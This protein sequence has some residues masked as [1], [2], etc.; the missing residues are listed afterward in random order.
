MQNAAVSS[1][2]ID[3]LPAD[4]VV[5][6]PD[7]SGLSSLAA[8]DHAGLALALEGLTVPEVPPARVAQ[9]LAV[10]EPDDARSGEDGQVGDAQI[11]AEVLAVMTGNLLGLDGQHQVPILASLDEFGDPVR[12]LD[13]VL[14]DFGYKHGKP[15]EPLGRGNPDDALICKDPQILDRKPQGQESPELWL[16][17]LAFL[18]SSCLHGPVD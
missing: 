15:Q 2:G 10:E 14:P 16:R 5:L 1:H 12:Q 7:P 3:D 4:A 17:C 18:A 6:A 13:E 11:E 9:R 8:L